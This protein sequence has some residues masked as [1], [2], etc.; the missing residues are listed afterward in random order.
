VKYDLGTG[1]YQ[2]Y[3]E[4]PRCWYSEAPFAPRDGARGEDEGYLVSFVWNS[5]ENRSE[6]QVFDAQHLGEGPIARAL[7]PQRVPNGFHATWVPAAQ[8]TS[9]R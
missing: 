8:L 4:G 5:N 3:S 2:A 6:L 9:P 7:L 1:A